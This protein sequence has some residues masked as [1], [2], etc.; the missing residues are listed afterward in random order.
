MAIG[1]Q[2]EAFKASTNREIDAAFV[3]L[4]QRRNEALLVAQ[5]RLFESRR[6]QLATLAAHYRLP[7]IYP[8]REFPEVGGLMSYGANL[9]DQFRQVG[10]YTGRILNGDKPADLPVI[11]PARLEFLINLQTARTLGNRRAG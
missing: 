3:A 5:S 2:V 4:M 7:A 9:R 10:V 8:L 6:A 1:A 11:Q